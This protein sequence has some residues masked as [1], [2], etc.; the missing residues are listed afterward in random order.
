MKSWRLPDVSAGC[1]NAAA[2]GDSDAIHTDIPVLPA[3]LNLDGDQSACA[4]HTS[5]LRGLLAHGQWTLKLPVPSHMRH[6]ASLLQV[7]L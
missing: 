6:S 5:R 7:A 1:E 3:E 4:F 2:I